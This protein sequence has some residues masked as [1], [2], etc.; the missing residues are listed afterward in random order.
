[1]PRTAGTTR[2]GRIKGIARSVRNRYRRL[3]Y[4]RARWA[5]PLGTRP[6]IGLAVC[7]IFRDEA[8]YLAEWV[9]F[10][11]LQGVERFYL[12]DNLST[13]DWRQEVAPELRSGVVEVTRWDQVPGQ[14]SAYEH[15]LQQH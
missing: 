11:R 10:H 1:M 14:G 9:T 8:R 5:P 3:G 4:L 2:P 12:Y 6:P 13:D 7:A 15:C